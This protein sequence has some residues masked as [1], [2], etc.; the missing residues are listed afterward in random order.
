MTPEEKKKDE[1]SLEEMMNWGSPLSRASESMNLSPGTPNSSTLD[2]LDDDDDIPIMRKS[3]LEDK[4][5]EEL[6]TNSDIIAKQSTQES[7][8]ES[9]FK[10]D[11][12]E[13]KKSIFDDSD[14][15]NDD[16]NEADIQFG[17]KATTQSIFEDAES[18]IK[19]DVQFGEK[20]TT[21]SIFEGDES[22]SN[23]DIVPE[24]NGTD[25]HD[26]ITERP[27]QDNNVTMLDSMAKSDS[28][29]S[30]T[31][32]SI[33]NLNSNVQTAT[34]V[35][36]RDDQSNK[37]A[38]GN[39]TE[40]LNEDITIDNITER[41]NPDIEMSSKSDSP[42]E[43]DS[44]ETETS[45][46][47]EATSSMPYFNTSTEQKSFGRI[48][49]FISSETEEEFNISKMQNKL[50]I[51]SSNLEKQLNTQSI[52]EIDRYMATTNIKQLDNQNKATTNIK[53]LDDQNTAIMNIK[54][55][56]GQNTVNNKKMSFGPAHSTKLQSCISFIYIG[57]TLI[58]SH[59]T[60]IKRC[61]NNSIVDKQINLV[62]FHRICMPNI[63]DKSFRN[64]LVFDILSLQIKNIT[65]DYPK[66][67][68][69]LNLKDEKIFKH[70]IMINIDKDL[71]NDPKTSLDTPAVMFDSLRNSEELSSLEVNLIRYKMG[72]PY[73]FCDVSISV[74]LLEQVALYNNPELTKR[75]IISQ[76][77]PII[78]FLVFYKLKLVNVDEYS[79]MFSKNLF[80]QYILSK[81]GVGNFKSK[82]GWNVRSIVDFGISKILN[83][84]N[85]YKT[86]NSPLDN[87]TPILDYQMKPEPEFT[88]YSS[89]SNTNI[90]E[91]YQKQQDHDVIA[92]DDKKQDFSHDVAH[93]TS[94][95]SKKSIFEDSD[96][97][98]VFE[99]PD[100]SSVKNNVFYRY[101][102]E[103]VA[104]IESLKDSELKND[105]NVN[106]IDTGM[107][108]TTID[109]D[110]NTLS[111]P[112]NNIYSPQTNNDPS[113]PHNH[114]LSTEIDKNTLSSPQ[115][116]NIVMSSSSPQTDN[117]PSSPQIY[118]KKFSKSFA[119]IF[120]LEGTEN[121]AENIDVSSYV[122]DP[123]EK[124][125]PI[126]LD[127]AGSRSSVVSSF[128]GFFKKK[129]P[130]A[131]KSQDDLMMNRATR[132]LKAEIKAPEKKER[133][134]I[135]NAYANRKDVG[136][137]EIP[138]FKPTKK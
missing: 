134:I 54:Q 33:D 55:V 20:A 101:S 58:T 83:V 36:D 69:I 7:G 129:T 119:D 2:F 79:F 26:I 67:K 103:S 110:N 116:D 44:K 113:S 22:D 4:S 120:T 10:N 131:P 73:S 15:E 38:V 109:T 123:G 91:D 125:K 46:F 25:L 17:E 137:F 86:P 30:I 74:N 92:E 63:D 61:L 128:F 62:E 133:K 14:S 87:I 42:N 80:H 45:F 66:I 84:E 19:T 94:E 13:K 5:K 49:E 77:N 118:K 115:D 96:E 57:D 117:D 56:N 32:I 72:L 99:K 108:I 114:I 107:S 138:G 95:V 127:D 28:L 100:Q 97:D 76:E 3:H 1:D 24:N 65:A 11:K 75:Y 121:V 122:S 50:G 41:L 40:N 105:E 130:D 6:V 18:D 132:P 37:T 82:N 89:D 39:L 112:H 85:E 60:N 9:M 98:F 64:H 104:S 53:Q 71:L 70:N 81:I 27:N 90:V 12:S 47:E 48:D 93:K 136:D 29:N 78:F 16:Q 68:S 111:S 51:E 106:T 124:D 126:L 43:V 8:N 102:N 34:L 31:D 59:I 135:H 21:Q 35:P 52:D 88:H 23:E